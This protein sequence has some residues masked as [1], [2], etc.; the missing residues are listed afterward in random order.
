MDDANCLASAYATVPGA[1]Y[2]S[3][4]CCALYLAG[5]ADE[6]MAG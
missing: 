5:N 1:P 6:A 2:L 3:E 4:M